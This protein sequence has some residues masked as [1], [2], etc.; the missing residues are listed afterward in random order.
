MHEDRCRRA[1]STE[2]PADPGELAMSR[3]CLVVAVVALSF[4]VEVSR[5]Q[6]QAPCPTGEF[7]QFRRWWQDWFN[8]N[9]DWERDRRPIY[10]ISLS[11]GAWTQNHRGHVN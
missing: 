2:R 10:T 11:P 8:D 3:W 6:P 1:C 5:A 7:V 4:G 9:T